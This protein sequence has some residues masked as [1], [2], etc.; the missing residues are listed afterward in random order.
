VIP[1]INL[2]EA[3][4][5]EIILLGEVILEIIL[6]KEVIPKKIP[7]EKVN[8]K[9]THIKMIIPRIIILMRKN[10]FRNYIDRCDSGNE[11]DGN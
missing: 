10:K 1:E 3:T 6:M 2:I 7:M 4:T 8:S 11:D 5:P 9:G